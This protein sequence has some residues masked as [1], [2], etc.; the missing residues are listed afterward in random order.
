M[1]SG[2][3]I[4]GTGDGKR[5]KT[6]PTE[7]QKRKEVE[8]TTDSKFPLYAFFRKYSKD[9]KLSYIPEQSIKKA[10]YGSLPRNVISK[11]KICEVLEHN[12]INLVRYRAFFYDEEEG[13]FLCLNDYDWIPISYSKPPEILGVI[14]KEVNKAIYVTLENNRL[15]SGNYH[16][17]KNEVN[18]CV[19]ERNGW[20]GIGIYR[21]KVE[22]NHGTLW[23]SSYQF[24]AAF[25]FSIGA[26]YKSKI[27]KRCDTYNTYTKIPF[28][29]FK[30]STQF[31]E[32][33]PYNAPWVAVEMGGEPLETFKHPSR[34][35]YILG[36]EDHGLSKDILARCRFRVT[37]PC[38]KD[39]NFNVA[40]AGSILM[41]D[42][43]VKQTIGINKSVTVK[44]QD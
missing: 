14:S 32:S 10:N 16:Q 4:D 39:S 36:S 12:N 7:T 3:R 18:R 35:V 15:P 43:H 11:E 13:A 29:Q 33:V 44:A 20:F 5:M 42:R 8:I 34:C 40:A 19:S 38:V 22:A 17:L 41:Y 26:R 2:K 23:R 31:L 27:E 37:L 25:V 30:D 28:L 21:G 9:I 6:C 1:R 24:G